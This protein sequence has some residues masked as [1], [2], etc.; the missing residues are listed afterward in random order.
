M[1]GGWHMLGIMYAAN[2]LWFFPNSIYLSGINLPIANHSH[3]RCCCW[4]HRA[5]AR[6]LDL[7]GTIVYL[8]HQSFHPIVGIGSPTPSPQRVCLP[9]LTQGGG[10]GGN[11]PLRVN[12]KPGTLCSVRLFERAVESLGAGALRYRGFIIV[13]HQCNG[14]RSIEY[15]DRMTGLQPTSIRAAIS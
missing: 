4:F 10:G 13:N 7:R 1:P 8:E 11:T 12:R 6:M 2:K 3:G 5:G 14:Q 15:D 9:P